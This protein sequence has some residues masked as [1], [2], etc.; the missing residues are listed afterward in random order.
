MANLYVWAD[1][2]DRDELEKMA[3]ELAR[4]HPQFRNISTKGNRFQAILD[5]MF[6]HG[7]FMEYYAA[8]LSIIERPDQNLDLALRPVFRPEDWPF[9]EGCSLTVRGYCPTQTGSPAG[10]PEALGRQPYWPTQTGSPVF[11]INGVYEG[12]DAPGLTLPLSFIQF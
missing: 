12:T 1:D 5:L 11:M 10:R 3:G 2:R 6:P 7:M 4:R 9:P 8:N